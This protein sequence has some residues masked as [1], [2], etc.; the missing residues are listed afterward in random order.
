MKRL[1]YFLIFFPALGSFGLIGYMV[2]YFEKECESQE[3]MRDCGNTNFFKSELQMKK[4]GEQ[5]F[6]FA[7]KHLVITPKWIED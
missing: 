3:S 7:D 6:Y 5:K 4:I 2:T 1:D